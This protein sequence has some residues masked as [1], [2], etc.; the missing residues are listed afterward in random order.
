LILLKRKSSRPLGQNKRRKISRQEEEK[1]DRGRATHKGKAREKIYADL[2]ALDRKKE[3]E[4]T[5]TISTSPKQKTKERGG[6]RNQQDQLALKKA[7]GG[8]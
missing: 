6:P 2:A 8:L 5:F 3:Q 1:G 4:T 7:K